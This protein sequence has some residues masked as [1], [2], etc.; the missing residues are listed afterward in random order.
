VFFFFFFF[1]AW[2]LCVKPLEGLSTIES[3][4]A[5]WPHISLGIFAGLVLYLLFILKLRSL[6]GSDLRKV[7]FKLLRA[8]TDEL[9]EQIQQDFFT[10]LV[11][12]NF[13]YIDQYYLQT[14]EQ[15]NKS[16]ALSA[17]AAVVGLAIIV[18]GI[19]MMFLG[20]IQ[21]AYLTTATGLV[22]EFISGAFFY[23]YNRTILKMSEYHQKLVLTQNIGLAL[24]I[25]E[26]LPEAAKVQSQQKLI[27]RLTENINLYLAHP[28]Q[29]E[30]R[31]TAKQQAP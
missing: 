21:A 12:I 19:I 3:L 8:G 18:T 22:S 27:E 6:Y 7:E 9:Q 25:S 15:A 28:P 4:K 30:Q 29:D 31:T 5:R 23:L 24:K 1:Y 2:T 16:F 20:R 26:T 14:Q 11:K 17:F 10:K 13:K